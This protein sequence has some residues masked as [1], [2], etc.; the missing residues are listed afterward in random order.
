[1]EWLEGLVHRANGCIF[2]RYICRRFFDGIS[3]PEDWTLHVIQN[4]TIFFVKGG[5]GTHADTLLGA[6]LCLHV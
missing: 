4:P 2:I 6:V 1:M 5:D 3:H